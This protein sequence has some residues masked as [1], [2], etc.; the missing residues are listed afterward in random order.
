MGCMWGTEDAR[1]CSTRPEKGPKERTQAPAH[2][3]RDPI[4]RLILC[5]NAM[6]DPS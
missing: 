2:L 3:R 4:V 1:Q 6:S 5:R